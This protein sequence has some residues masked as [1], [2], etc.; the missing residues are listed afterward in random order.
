MNT[1][2]IPAGARLRKQKLAGRKPFLKPSNPDLIALDTLGALGRRKAQRFI[3]TGELA[4]VEIGGRDYA[5]RGDLAD[6]EVIDGGAAVTPS[7]EFLGD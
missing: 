3:E 7:G 6:W 2:V 4:T 1:R 5:T